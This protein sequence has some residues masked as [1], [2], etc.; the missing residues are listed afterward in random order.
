[1]PLASGFACHLGQGARGGNPDAAITL[2]GSAYRCPALRIGIASIV[3]SSAVAGKGLALRSFSPP[4]LPIRIAVK[5]GGEVVFAAKRCGWIAC[6]TDGVP[7]DFDDSEVAGG[8]VN[9]PPSE[10]AALLGELRD[11]QRSEAETINIAPLPLHLR[12]GG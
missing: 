8:G 1:M 11:L 4:S 10:N 3:A 7:N 5:V 12:N 2:I 6:A 9:F